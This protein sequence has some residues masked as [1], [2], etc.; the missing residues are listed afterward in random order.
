MKALHHHENADRF[1]Q[2]YV[3]IDQENGRLYAFDWVS[4]YCFEIE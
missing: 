3:K 2:N 4:A 1:F